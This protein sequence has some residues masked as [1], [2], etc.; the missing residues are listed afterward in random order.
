M[1]VFP[2][3]YKYRGVL[4][5]ETTD[6]VVQGHR[7]DIMERI[8]CWPVTVNTI[9]AYFLIFMWPTVLGMITMVY[10]GWSSEITSSMLNILFNQLHSSHLSSGFRPQTKAQGHAEIQS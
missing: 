10:A 3:R 1:C 7:F 6:Y 2:V 8:G 4:S 9:A 5:K